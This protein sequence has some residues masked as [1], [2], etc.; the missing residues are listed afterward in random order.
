M[1]FN[2]LAEFTVACKL[3]YEA[4]FG[5]PGRKIVWRAGPVEKLHPYFYVL[6]FAPSG[7]KSTWTYCTVGMSLDRLSESRI[8]LFVL[9][10]R[11]DESLAELLLSCASFH[12]NDAPLDLNHTVNI[13]RPWLADSCCDYA[14]IS[15]PY[16]HGEALELFDFASV[17]TH[18]YWLIPITEAERDYK[19][20]HGAEALEQLFEQQELDYLNPKRSCLI[21]P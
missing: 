10:P 17:T 18:C 13:G 4:Y 21:S 1:D 20:Q 12:R 14:F 3:H 5:K 16:L 19:I 8:E 7:G 9:S 15:L 11:Q 2:D 6:E